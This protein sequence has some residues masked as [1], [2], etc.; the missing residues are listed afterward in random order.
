VEPQ[1]VRA[2]LIRTI[3]NGVSDL[4]A[5]Y[6]H[7]RKIG[8]REVLEDDFSILKVSFY[9]R[10]SRAPLRPAPR[11][12]PAAVSHLGLDRPR[13]ATGVK[14]GPAEARKLPAP[15]PIGKTGIA[16]AEECL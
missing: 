3:A 13:G 4:D 16:R 10:W 7:V 14:P 8:G 1:G 9:V 11:L 15:L 5:L 6:C 2:L 12:T